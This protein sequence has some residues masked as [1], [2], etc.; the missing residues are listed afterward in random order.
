[1]WVDIRVRGMYSS[2]YKEPVG[3]VPT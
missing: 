3:I 1:M 2:I